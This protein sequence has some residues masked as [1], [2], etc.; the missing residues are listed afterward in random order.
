MLASV[1]RRRAKERAEAI[2][3]ALATERRKTG[4]LRSRPITQAE[5]EQMVDG[6]RCSGE[7]CLGWPT[8]N[9]Y[10]WWRIALLGNETLAKQLRSG[11]A[12]SADG[13]VYLNLEDASIVQ[14]YLS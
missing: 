4:W 10:A 7:D 12:L 9:D 14:S 1:E 6:P 13:H 8:W 3:E 2:K 11:A 5:A